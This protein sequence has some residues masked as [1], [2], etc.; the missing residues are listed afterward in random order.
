MSEL[1]RHI[2]LLLAG[3]AHLSSVTV[4]DAYLLQARGIDWQPFKV[5]MNKIW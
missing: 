4:Q 2:F 1:K 5:L 3:I